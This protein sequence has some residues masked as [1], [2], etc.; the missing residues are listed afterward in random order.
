MLHKKA[1]VRLVTLLF[2]FTIAVLIASCVQ[3]QKNE[4]I[5]I[6][7]GSL[8]IDR[9]ER[10]LKQ[11]GSSNI[12]RMKQHYPDF[13]DLYCFQVIRVGDPDTSILKTRIADFTSNTDI[14]S[15]YR[16]VQSKFPEINFLEDKLGNAFAH[17][18]HYFPEK[19]IPEVLTYISGFVHSI[20][21]ADSVL[22]IG[23]DMYL[24]RESGYYPALQFPQY[25]INKLSQEYI[26]ADAMRSW[27]ETEWAFPQEQTDLISQMIYKGKIL[28]VLKTLLPDEPDSI[29]TGY[30]QSQIQWCEKSEKDVWSFF[31]DHKLI[32]STEQNHVMKY[33]TEGPTTNGFPK[34][35]PGNIGQW[36]G[37]QIVDA[38]MKGH[39][40]MTVNDL[41]KENDY[42][43]ILNESNYKPGK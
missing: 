31:I 30:S 33:V 40:E 27:I 2:Y 43:K 12:G 24:G 36:I 29:L 15:V 16:D 21:C 38:Y 20:I 10:D 42:K 35:S 9:F 17:Y 18:K 37:F 32:F 34:E 23:L 41:L 19:N 8:H 1:G 14:D 4:A 3:N 6:T 39:P 11:Y 13:F 5:V 26:V 22:G 7:P 25:K 28:M